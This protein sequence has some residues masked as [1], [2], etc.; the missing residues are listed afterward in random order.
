[1]KNFQTSDNK[2]LQKASTGLLWKLGLVEVETNVQ[3]AQP[4]DSP[5]SY[6]E[7]VQKGHV[8]LSYSWANQGQVKQIKDK[9]EQAGYDIWMDV[10]NI[11]KYTL[12]SKQLPKI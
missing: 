9:L 10:G 5:P 1:M 3:Q 4:L 6:E 11:S 7:S 12:Y 2:D 8:M